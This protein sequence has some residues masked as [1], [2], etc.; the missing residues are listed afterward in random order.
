LIARKIREEQL[1]ELGSPKVQVYNFGVS[2]QKPL[3]DFFTDNALDFTDLEEGRDVTIHQEQPNIRDKRQT[4]YRVS[5][6]MTPSKAPISQEDVDKYSIDLDTLMPFMDF[7]QA[8]AAIQGATHK[9]VFALKGKSETPQVIK[10]MLAAPAK[11]I[12]GEDPEEV[13]EELVLAPTPPKSAPSKPKASKDP[14]DQYLDADGYIDFSKVSDE[15]I[16]YAPNQSLIAKAGTTEAHS[17]H[18]SC[19]GDVTQFNASDDNCMVH[20]VLAERCELRINDKAPKVAP[21]KRGAPGKK[22]AVPV[23]E[24]VVIPKDNT[25]AISSLEDQMRAALAG[26][27]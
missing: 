13:K 8:E 22:A 24:P 19:F 14:L 21:V 16:E 9:E 23:V 5:F 26:K 15:M 7:S 1:P 20:C 11:E 6:A 27:M 17:I 18:V 4:E 3:L 12:E 10:G 2:I 25:S